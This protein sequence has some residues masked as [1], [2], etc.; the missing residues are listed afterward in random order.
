[1]DFFTYDEHAY[2]GKCVPSE[3]MVRIWDQEKLQFIGPK[4]EPTSNRKDA[5]VIKFSDATD[6]I[7]KITN[8]SN[9]IF[10]EVKPH[11]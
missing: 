10:E 6:F 4:K 9:L 2:G 7:R 8:R 3:K 5:E 11:G 1:M